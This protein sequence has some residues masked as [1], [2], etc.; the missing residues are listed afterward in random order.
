MSWLDFVGQ[1]RDILVFFISQSAS[2]KVKKATRIFL[3]PSVANQKEVSQE[4]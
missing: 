3:K 4:S 1:R 2:A